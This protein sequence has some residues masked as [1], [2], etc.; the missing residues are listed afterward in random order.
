MIPRQRAV[1]PCQFLQAY[2]WKIR[3]ALLQVKVIYILVKS[4]FSMKKDFFIL[5]KVCIR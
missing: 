4:F 5:F 1:V 2:A 3:R